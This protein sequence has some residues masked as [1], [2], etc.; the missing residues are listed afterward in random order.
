[1]RRASGEGNCRMRAPR[2]GGAA[3]CAR[4]RCSRRDVDASQRT[5]IAG[6]T[7]E[8]EWTSQGEAELRPAPAQATA[9]TSWTS[10]AVLSR[11]RRH[12]APALGSPECRDPAR[13]AEPQPAE[14]ADIRVKRG[15]RSD[16]QNARR[17]R[18]G[19]QVAR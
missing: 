18:L 10:T 17:A 3:R 11:R 7:A 8:T 19:L 16:V 9:T 14:A 2:T 4:S 13:E 1:M 15:R 5:K 6:D 12:D